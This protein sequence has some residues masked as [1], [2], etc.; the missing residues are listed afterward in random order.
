MKRKLYVME[1][2]APYTGGGLTAIA[3]DVDDLKK[4]IRS[5][6][7]KYPDEF[8]LICDERLIQLY[9]L[10]SQPFVDD[11]IDRDSCDLILD[12]LPIIKDEINSIIDNDKSVL[13][14]SGDIRLDWVSNKIE[15]PEGIYLIKTLDLEINFSLP[16]IVSDTY[17]MA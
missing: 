8:E 2:F 16:Q 3:L 4:V 11:G 14:K 15:I 7:H 1:Y 13:L 6:N 5:Y 9:I 10:R 12:Q 17:Y